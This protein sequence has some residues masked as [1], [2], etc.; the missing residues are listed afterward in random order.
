M[1]PHIR[2]LLLALALPMLCA[3]PAL[4]HATAARGLQE[5]HASYRVWWW[6]CLLATVPISALMGLT[7]STPRSGRAGKRTE[8]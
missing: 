1:S 6:L 8:D 2:R 3:F 5:G 4:A 7:L